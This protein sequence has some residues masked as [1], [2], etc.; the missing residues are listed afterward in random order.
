MT[1]PMTQHVIV[2]WAR[3]TAADLQRDGDEWDVDQAD[4]DDDRVTLWRDGKIVAS[5]GRYDAAVFLVEDLVDDL[6][7][8]DRHSR[9]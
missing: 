4:V 5:F 6:S 2:Q 7:A 3:N 9:P 8:S 1:V